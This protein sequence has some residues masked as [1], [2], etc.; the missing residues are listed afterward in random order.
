[1]RGNFEKHLGE[2]V[3]SYSSI[4]QS[5]QAIPGDP[6]IVVFINLTE[7]LAILA[8]SNDQFVQFRIGYWFRQFSIH[9]LIT[10]RSG[11][12]LQEFRQ[13]FRTGLLFRLLTSDF[14]VNR[15]DFSSTKLSSRNLPQRRR[16]TEV[17]DEDLCPTPFLRLGAL[18]FIFF[19]VAA[20]R[21]E[22]RA[23]RS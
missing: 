23:I 22:I 7:C 6:R 2:H 10:A 3:F 9:A 18:R 12:L 5:P 1:M 13:D 8:N 20:L 15:E 19:L 17:N 21:W 16:D 14:F 11:L 4:R